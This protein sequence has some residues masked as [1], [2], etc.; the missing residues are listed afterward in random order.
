M[1]GNLSEQGAK[2]LR[3]NLQQAQTARALQLLEQESDFHKRANGVNA[4]LVDGLVGDLDPK[5]ELTQERPHHRRFLDL[6]I[7]GY[8]PTEIA[9]LTGFNVSTISNCIKQPW[10]RK[11]IIDNSK[12]SVQD[13]MKEF[14]EAEVLPSLKVL[15]AVRDGAEVRNQDRL[16]ASNALLD[17]YLGKPVQPINNDAKPVSDLSD[18]ELKAEVQRELA[19]SQAN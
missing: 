6:T 17:R 19:K 5:N 1:Q 9:K 14:L 15:K 10:A 4:S 8:I 3:S 11:Y 2:A 12:R 13:E 18:E 16:A 7:Q